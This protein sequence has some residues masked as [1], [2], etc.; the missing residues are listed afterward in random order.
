MAA[1]DMTAHAA[2]LEVCVLATTGVARGKTMLS[3]FGL[4]MNRRMD[5]G[6]HAH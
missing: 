6:L 3:A 1:A 4:V 5:H 2:S